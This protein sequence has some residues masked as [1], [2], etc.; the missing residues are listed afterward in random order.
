[1]NL[2]NI[3]NSYISENYEFLDASSKTCQDVI[4]SKISK[5]SLSKNIT[6]KGGV[7]IQHI[8]NDKRRAT[9]DFD[10]DFIKYSLNENAINKFIET[11]NKVN[12]GIT[13]N[14]VEPIQELNHQE[15][16]GKRV[17]IELIDVQNNIIKTKL[18]IGIHQ[19]IDIKQEQIITERCLQF[20][21]IVAPTLN[22]QIASAAIN[23]NPK[24]IE[25][26]TDTGEN[27][28]VDKEQHPEVYD[29]AVNG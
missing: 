6:I 9:R 14:I 16:Q 28:L 24:I 20:Q 11:L 2:N 1:M 8:S 5:S 3:R 29:W 21:P 23:N 10:L 26:K 17:I 15:Y 25:L 22:E 12:D 18:D 27:I 13:I 19:S 4:L 7:I